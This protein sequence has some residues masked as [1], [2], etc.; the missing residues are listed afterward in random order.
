MWLLSLIVTL[1]CASTPVTVG[2]QGLG[3]A[4]T[5]HGMIADPSGGA[6]QAVQVRISNP[7]TGFSR[8]AT[9]DASGRYL[10]GNLPPNTYHL[11]VE[12]QGFEPAER[13]VEVRSGVPIT[14]D[15]TLSTNLNKRKRQCAS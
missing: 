12:A 3:G 14:I 2:A 6:M 8:I 1:S 5:I 15:L 9:T 13:Q 11:V 4:G 10:F 7:V